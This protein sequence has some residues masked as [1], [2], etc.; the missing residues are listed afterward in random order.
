MP[1]TLRLMTL[2][3]GEHSLGTLTWNGEWEVSGEVE[4]VFDYVDAVLPA[5]RVSRR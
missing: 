1:Y 5:C 2:I 4:W 3:G